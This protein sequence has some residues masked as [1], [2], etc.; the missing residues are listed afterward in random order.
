MALLGKRKMKDVQTADAKATESDVNSIGDPRLHTLRRKQSDTTP[1]AGKVL[2]GAV[3]NKKSS[4]ADDI[5]A[6]KDLAKEA[7]NLETESRLKKYLEKQSVEETEAV[8]EDADKKINAESKTLLNIADEKEGAAAA[9]QNRYVS[10]TTKQEI[11]KDIIDSNTSDP[12]YAA[13]EQL[14]VQDYFPNIGKDIAVGTYSGRRIGSST[15]YAAPGARIPFGVIDARERQLAAAAQA[16]QKQLDDLKSRPDMV[17]QFKLE[18]DEYANDEIMDILK[19][20]NY[21]PASVYRD[22]DAVQR[23]SR[24]E[25]TAKAFTDADA[26]IDALID[27]RFTADGKSK[28]YLPAEA[29]KFMNDFRSGILDDKEAYFKG[30]K[31]ISEK[32]V[33]LNALS[34]GVRHVDELMAQIENQQIEVPLNLK[35]G[36][37]LDQAAIQ[38]LNSAYQLAKSTNSYDAYISAVKKYFDIKPEEVLN[39]WFDEKGY[40]KDDPARKWAI[41]YFNALV[42]RESIASKIEFQGN[43]K[44][45]YWNASQGRE[46]ERKMKESLWQNIV[47]TATAAGITEEIKAKESILRNTTDTKKRSE[48]IAE[49]YN[50]DQLMKS[51]G[52]TAQIDPNDNQRVY[53]T[54]TSAYQ[55]AE[56]AATVGNTQ[57]AIYAYDKRHKAYKWVSLEKINKGAVL[58]SDGT[59]N[60]NASAYIPQKL[61]QGGT[62]G[63][64]VSNN[65][66]KQYEQDYNLMYQQ[67]K[68]GSIPLSGRSY[69]TQLGYTQ[70]NGDLM[71]LTSNNYGSYNA[72]SNKTVV[73]DVVG[74]PVVTGPDGKKRLSSVEVKSTFNAGETADRAVLDVMWSAEQ[75]NTSNY[76]TP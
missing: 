72:A 29:L 53:G 59:I 33:T 43:K 10:T 9:N 75:K 22:K 20:H 51:L 49:I 31:N 69:K 71:P 41:D 64:Y 5:F 1:L 18:F 21:D 63:I 42:P 55:D 40:A 36:V 15:I 61:T 35:Q 46:H 74:N 19:S 62:R 48:I 13:L 39:P 11:E 66:N 17:A 30:E 38:D 44:F 45:E 47:N 2:L 27:G 58:K 4:T 7:N 26:I 23:L 25:N 32:M 24:L 73:V 52:F 12:A 16:K 3:I 76:G 6:A 57:G 54:M 67:S 8:L 34:D 60:W 56:N 14:S 70:Q 65:A 68:G 37:M 28:Y 50:K